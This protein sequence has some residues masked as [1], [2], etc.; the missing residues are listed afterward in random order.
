MDERD[1]SQQ[2]PGQQGSSAHK[3]GPNRQRFRGG[4]GGTLPLQPT[5]SSKGKISKSAEYRSVSIDV[6]SA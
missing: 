6:S 4:A 1:G 5:N 3:I 2:A